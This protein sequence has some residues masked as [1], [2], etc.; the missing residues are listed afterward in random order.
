MKNCSNCVYKDL[1]ITQEPCMRC[2]YTEYWEADEDE[3]NDNEDN[4]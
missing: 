3:E 2:R 4:Q 1:L